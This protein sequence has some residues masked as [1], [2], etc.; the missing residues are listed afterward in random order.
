MDGC[1][2]DRMYEV[3]WNQWMKI[4]IVPYCILMNWDTSY[5]PPYIDICDSEK[6]HGTSSIA[7]SRL[8]DIC[9]HFS[10]WVERLI[11]VLP[12]KKQFIDRLH[13]EL[14]S[15]ELHEITLIVW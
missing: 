6:E 10:S 4:R 15:R 5:C 7:H 3:E 14:I 9:I 12:R 8:N 1:D 11:T 2:Q 13:E